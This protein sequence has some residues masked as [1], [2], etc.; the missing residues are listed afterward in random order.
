MKMEPR[1][2]RRIFRNA[3]LS[4]LLYA[5]PVLLMFATFYVTGE[6]PWRQAA[7]THQSR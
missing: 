3:L 6:R 5:L 4:L 7:K 1:V 2:A